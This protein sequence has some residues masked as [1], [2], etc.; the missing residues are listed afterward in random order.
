VLAVHVM[1]AGG[2]AF[3]YGV[4]VAAFIIGAILY[5]IAQPKHLRWAPVFV[6]SGLAI[7]FFVAF[8]NALALS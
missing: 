1:S 8:Y 5:A 6:A 4:A 7:A 2:Q 3:F